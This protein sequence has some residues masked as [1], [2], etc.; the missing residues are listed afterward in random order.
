MQAILLHRKFKLQKVPEL[1]FNLFSVSRAAKAGKTVEFGRQGCRIVEN[2]TR[3]TIGSGRKKGNLYYV[4]CVRREER[5]SSSKCKERG[6]DSKQM[7]RALHQV[8]ESNFEREMM[9]RLERVEREV[10][11]SYYNKGG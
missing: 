8:S 9:K 5:N 2:S 1:K 4:N 3:K 7:Q 11:H 10:H 6:L